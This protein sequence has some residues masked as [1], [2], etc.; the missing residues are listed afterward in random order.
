MKRNWKRISNRNKKSNNKGIGIVVRKIGRI[1]DTGK[2]I[3]IVNS[4]SG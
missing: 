2:E 3:M 4:K 1:L